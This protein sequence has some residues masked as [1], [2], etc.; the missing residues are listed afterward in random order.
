MWP[1]GEETPV[2][3]AFSQ[4]WGL[5]LAVLAVIPAMRT[6]QA[7][8]SHPALARLPRDRFSLWLDRALRALGCFSALCLA[9]GIAGPHLA[10]QWRERIG[11]GAHIVILLDRSSSMNENFSGRYLGGKAGETKNAVASRLLGE[12]VARR[13]NDL[14]ALVAFSAAP[15]YVMPLTQ[16]RMAVQTAIASLGRRGHGVTNIAPGLAMALDYFGGRPVTGSRLILL[17]S[18]GAARMEPETGD[19]IRQ[20]FQDQ[21]ASLYWIY[22]RNPKSASLTAPPK[23][24]NEST[25]P[26]FFLHQ[27]FQSLEVPYRAYEAENPESVQQ[28]IRDLEQLENQPLHY[29][30]KQPREDLSGYCYGAALAALLVLAAFRFLEVRQWRR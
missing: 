12:F 26:E 14:F 30:E 8:L 16:D 1:A 23:A 6:G 9:T 27:Y 22:L 5:L 18:D 19:M 17:V 25:T 21:K 13:E 2:S 20:L 4:P 28:A 11:T 10:E 15:I 3:L 7:R 29:L 24:P